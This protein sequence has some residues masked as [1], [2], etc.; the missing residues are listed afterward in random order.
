MSK[1]ACTIH[2]RV[3]MSATLTANALKNRQPDRW[4]DA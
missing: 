1:T 2:V 4:T 3:L